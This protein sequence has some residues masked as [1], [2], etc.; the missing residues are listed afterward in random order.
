LADDYFK[1]CAENFRFV[2]RFDFDI[3]TTWQVELAECIYCT[4]AACIDVKQALVRVQLKLLTSFL[5]YVG[6]AQY[7][8]NFL[9]RRQRNWTSN[10][11][12]CTAY[13]FYDFLSRFVN[14]IVVVRL[15]FD[16]NAL[17]HISKTLYK[18]GSAKV[19][20]ILEVTKDFGRIFVEMG[21][22]RWPFLL[23]IEV[24]SE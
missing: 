20:G 5:V 19:G 4:A 18:F 24:F 8:K 16:S 9:V 7:R 15:Q 1:I 23:E 3:N 14:Q 22:N 17:R 2:L 6:R 13:S 11:G 12:T 21:K 10:Y